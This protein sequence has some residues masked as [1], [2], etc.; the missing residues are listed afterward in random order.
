MIDV[1]ASAELDAL[2][3]SNL[4]GDV[5]CMHGFSLG[6]QRS[7]QIRNVRLM[8]LAMMQLHDLS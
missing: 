4:R 5:G 1:S 6:L 2:L 7:I 3:Q 8:V